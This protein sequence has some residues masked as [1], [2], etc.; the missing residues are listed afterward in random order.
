MTKMIKQLKELLEMQQLLDY[1][2]F[3]KKGIKEYP[4]QSMRIALFVELGEM[5]NEFPTHFKHWKSTAKD[6]REKGL[7]EFVDSLHFALSLSNYEKVQLELEKNQAYLEYDM[8]DHDFQIDKYELMWL[9]PDVVKYRGA[10]R[11]HYLLM[12]G[13]YFGFT[14]DEIYNAYIEKN[15]V[16]YERIKNNY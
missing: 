1:A 6:D 12:I 10:Q 8:L 5:M 14:W 7:V 13:K 9:L 2:I 3:T 4:V 15:K 11:L 16:N